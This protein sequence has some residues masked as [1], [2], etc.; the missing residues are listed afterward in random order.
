MELNADT[1][2]SLLGV[3][4]NPDGT[5]DY[6]FVKPGDPAGGDLGG[7]YPNPTVESIDNVEAAIIQASGHRLEMRYG[8][9]NPFVGGVGFF[10]YL[11]DTFPNT[12][13]ATASGGAIPYFN[14]NTTQRGM[15]GS[16]FS[17]TAFAA[18]VRGVWHWEGIAGVNDGY[19]KVPYIAFG[20]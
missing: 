4:L 2:A 9:T 6:E 13:I 11:I 15:A 12:C 19:W 10:D 20:Y 16:W 5:I 18:Q 14:D 1:F 7:T 17:V 8:V 3:H